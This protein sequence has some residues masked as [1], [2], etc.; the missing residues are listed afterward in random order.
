M[1]SLNLRQLLLAAP[2]GQK[3]V[4]GVDPGIRTGCKVVCLDAQGNLLY[5]DVVYPFTPRG[6]EHAA[7]MEFEKIA[8][9]FKVEAIAVGMALLVA[10]QPISCALRATM[11]TPEYPCMW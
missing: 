8:G 5:H 3:R 9:R 7:K 11:R 10:K 2:L 6:N 4:M 1:F